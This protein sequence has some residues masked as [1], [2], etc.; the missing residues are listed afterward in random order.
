MSPNPDP[1][2][3][4]VRADRK[5]MA[6]EDQAARYALTEP[7]PGPLADA[8]AIV[9]GI[10]VGPYTVRPFYDI[11]YEFLDLLKH[12]LYRLM[13]E[14]ILG[15]Q[16][17][18]EYFPMGLPAWQACWIMTH[19]PKEVLE[20]LQKG[21]AELLNSEAR[22]TFGVLRIGALQALSTAIVKQI[23]IYWSTAIAYGPATEKNED[24]E[25]A[26]DGAPQTPPNPSLT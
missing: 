24:Q 7:L 9:P 18:V 22:A 23:G 10:T 2:L 8:F 3:E 5:Q 21:G 25:P 11:D 26:K 17:K 16:V 14:Q 12:P 6:V 19:E 4:Q 20:T 1:V 13:Q 15:T